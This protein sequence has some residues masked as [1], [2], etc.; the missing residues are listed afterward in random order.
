MPVGVLNALY[1][2]HFV[3]KA[4]LH[5][6]RCF[7]MCHAVHPNSKHAPLSKIL[8]NGLNYECMFHNLTYESSVL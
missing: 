8:T 2:G 1:L 7:V 5:Q 6:R 4:T 3:G